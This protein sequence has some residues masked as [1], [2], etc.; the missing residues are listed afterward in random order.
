M[1]LRWFEHWQVYHPRRELCVE[2]AEL[3]F[4]FEDVRFEA[5]DGIK[6]HAWFFPASAQRARSKFVFLVCHGNGGNVSH[7]VQLYQ[8]LLA[9]GTSVFAFDYRGYGRS[10]GRCSEAGTYLD[11]QAA[12]RWLQRRG[13]APETI[14]LFGESL[15][16]AVASDLA[17]RERVGGLVLQST[18]TSI[19]DIG[20]ELFPWLPVR[21]LGSIRYDTLSRLPQIKVPLLIMHSRADRLVGFHHAEKNFA[22]ANEPKLLWELE[23]DH[24]DSLFD[25]PRLLKGIERFL[26]MVEAVGSSH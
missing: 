19:P 16:G 14:L 23:G 10:Q 3:G 18:F 22:A 17:T 7:R 21:R 26:Q 15:G 8:T 4:P 24:N 6:L 20:A 1:L 12:Y 2:A 11:A 13:F 25:A 9:T 5:S